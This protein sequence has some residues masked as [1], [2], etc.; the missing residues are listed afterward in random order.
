MMM[1]I[2]ER[3]IVASFHRIYT[4]GSCLGEDCLTM[5]IDAPRP[6]A[7]TTLSYAT[8]MSLSRADIMQ[9]VAYFPDERAKIA[10]AGAR[11]RAR[12]KILVG[13]N[14]RR[15]GSFELRRVTQWHVWLHEHKAPPPPRLPDVDILHSPQS[16]FF[17]EPRSNLLV[18]A[19][20]W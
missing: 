8:L 9:V 19:V 16:S 4:C 1:F 2:V 20:L 17:V 13:R 12:I 10:K 18:P 11:V 6:Y 14:G 3:G 15:V 5:P 7:A